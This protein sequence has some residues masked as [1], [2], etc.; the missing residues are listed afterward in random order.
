MFRTLTTSAIALILATGLAAPAS[1]T[2][3][4]NDTTGVYTATLNAKNTSHSAFGSKTL[5]ASFAL[6]GKNVVTMSAGCNTISGPIKSWNGSTIT[7]GKLTSTYMHCTGLAAHAEAALVRLMSKPFS[8]NM[9]ASGVTLDFEGQRLVFDKE[10]AYGVPTYYRFL[11]PS[12]STDEGLRNT[13]SK[14]F[15]EHHEDGQVTGYTGCRAFTAKRVDAKSHQLTDVMMDR[16][17][18]AGEA[19]VVEKA[20][21]TA[22]GA[23]TPARGQENVKYVF[24]L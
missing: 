21:L 13:T 8:Y 18:C 6:S 3:G 10:A 24:S 17:G 14:A 23:I 11:S 2:A 4:N 16:R 19:A 12:E 20:F 22:V 7:L 15:L 9:T 1:A 5:D